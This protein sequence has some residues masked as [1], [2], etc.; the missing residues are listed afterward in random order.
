MEQRTHGGGV[1]DANDEW[2][3]D[4]WKRRRCEKDGIGILDTIRHLTSYIF[5]FLFLPC[6]ISFFSYVFH[7]SNSP[8]HFTF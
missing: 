7:F 2:V 1:V 5:V 4:Q 6:F 3:W 8:D